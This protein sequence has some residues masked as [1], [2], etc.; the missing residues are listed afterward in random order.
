MLVLL[1]FLR[2]ISDTVIHREK[3]SGMYFISNGRYSLPPGVYSLSPHTHGLAKQYPGLKHLLLLSSTPGREGIL[4]H[5]A[6]RA[7]QLS[8]CF[9][10]G[11]SLGALLNGQPAVLQSVSAMERILSEGHSQIVI[12]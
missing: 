4:I 11:M 1:P 2:G 12:S 10:P 9:A 6:N 5:P 7:A 8:G 3:T